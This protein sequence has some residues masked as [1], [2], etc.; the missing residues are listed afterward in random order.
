M[1]YITVVRAKLKDP[2]NAQAAHDATVRLLSPMTRPVGALHH[3]PF[4]NPQNSSE[5]LA[6]DTWDNIEGLQK[7]MAN[8]QVLTEFGK[9]FDGMP[10]ISVWGE[11]PWETF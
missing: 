7:F 9:L 5:F 1:K 8:P 3:N 4:L 6:I 11:A 2:A 10:E